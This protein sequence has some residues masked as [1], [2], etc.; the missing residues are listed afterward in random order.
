MKRWAAITVLLYATVALLLTVPLFLAYFA[1]MARPDPVG[2]SIGMM[3]EF[4][5]EPLLSSVS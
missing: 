3:R 4:L 1:P 5:P 2:D